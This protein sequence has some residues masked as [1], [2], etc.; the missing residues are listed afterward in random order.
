MEE[1]RDTADLFVNDS[2]MRRQEHPV[3]CVQFDPR[4]RHPDQA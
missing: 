3:S 4:P 2:Q 1:M